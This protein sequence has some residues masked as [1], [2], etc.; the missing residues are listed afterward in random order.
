M[1]N[2]AAMIGEFGSPR[3][4]WDGLDKKTIQRVKSMLSNLNLAS[5]TW[6]ATILNH[7]TR[8][9][10]L[11]IIAAN[12]NQSQ[13]QAQQNFHSII[14]NIRVFGS[15]DIVTKTYDSGLVISAVVLKYGEGEMLVVY[16]TNK[17]RNSPISTRCLTINRSGGRRIEGLWFASLS[18]QDEAVDSMLTVGL[19]DELACAT[20]SCVMVMPL[21]HHYH[22]VVDNNQQM[23]KLCHVID[24][25]HWVLDENG[26]MVSNIYPEDLDQ[27]LRETV[28]NSED[29]E[30]DDE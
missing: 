23:G 30:E 13:H 18:W 1:L 24:V 6:L 20:R 15:Q 12:M 16:K 14:G 8:E 9:Q 25:E 2:L 21:D 10:T 28:D 27:N 4:F 26:W 3:N 17:R 11:N 22:D 7:V 5:D 19:K 29:L